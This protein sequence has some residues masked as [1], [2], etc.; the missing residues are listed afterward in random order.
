MQLP[1]G[2]KMFI[3][4]GKRIPNE[5]NYR[6]TFSGL[7]KKRSRRRGRRRRTRK[8]KELLLN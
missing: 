7:Q 6:K 1:I 3:R 8:R 2:W 4:L 5:N